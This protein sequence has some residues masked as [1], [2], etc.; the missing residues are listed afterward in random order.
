MIDWSPAFLELATAVLSHSPDLTESEFKLLCAAIYGEAAYCGPT[1]A[2][3]HP[4]NDPQFADFW[5]ADRSIRAELLRWLCVEGAE[6]VDPRGIIVHGAWVEGRLNLRSASLP[7]PLVLLRCRVDVLD[8]S[9]AQIELLVLSGCWVSGVFGQDLS[10]RL[11]VIFNEGFWSEGEVRLNGAH[12]GADLG[13]IGGNFSA[14]GACAISA[15]GIRVGGTIFL[16]RGFKAQGS[17]RLVGAEIGGYL[18]CNGGSF[19]N[20]GGHALIADGVKVGLGIQMAQGFVAEGEVRLLRAKVGADLACNGGRFL[21]AKGYALNADGIRVGRSVHLVGN[22]YSEGEVCLVGADVGGNLECTGARL[23]NAGKIAL[24][25]DHIRVGRNVFLRQG[26][27]SVGETRLVGAEI[28]GSLE[29]GSPE[30]S[31][32]TFTN[33]GATAL[34]ACR[35]RV[36]GD[37]HFSFGFSAA[38]GVH[39]RGAEIDGSL[40]CVGARFSNPG[41]YAVEAQGMKVGGSVAFRS[42]CDRGLLQ[43]TSVQGALNLLGVRVAR[44]L[45][46]QA[47]VFDR[48]GLEAPLA[49]VGGALFWTRVGSVGEVFL[50]LGDASAGSIG[51]DAE[52]WPKMG[53]LNLDGFVFGRIGSGPADAHSRLQ[54][55][56]LQTGSFRAQPYEQ[57][58]KVLR[59]S[60]DERGARA[61]YI[62][63]RRALRKSGSLAKAARR[64]DWFLDW[65]VRYGYET[66]RALLG[67][68]LIVVI[69]AFPFWNWFWNMQPSVVPVATISTQASA[70]GSSRETRNTA[71][72]RPAA[73]GPFVR[74]ADRFLFSLFYSLDTFL[75]FGHFEVRSSHPL[76]PRYPQDL[77]FY[78]YE[79]CY[80]LEAISG[81]FIVGLIAAALT[82]LARR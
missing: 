23:S 68:L 36:A 32:G 35:L 59:S 67:A 1:P 73:G 74:A 14:P 77:W 21:N 65:S 53:N 19:S 70:T 75:P 44:N 31:G 62:E 30:R 42:Q 58:E 33:P 11:S 15:D 5:G 55:L 29:C 20:S 24:N 9:C 72:Q 48:G 38:G 81:W 26:F 34:E 60:G 49:T 16:N 78:F 52:S 6:A 41:N 76:R 3:D 63:K 79:F 17:V 46:V 57:L 54:W 56:G 13:C 25:A 51:D 82:G 45:E 18:D 40:T 27:V 2:D 39:L 28:G 7:F 80:M 8:I 22:F 66:W 47:A 37:V 71:V 69:G 61:V 10:A 50:N 64:L 43:L 12:I 4:H